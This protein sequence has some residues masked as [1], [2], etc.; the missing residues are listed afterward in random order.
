[1]APEVAMLATRSV[2]SSMATLG[3]SPAASSARSF[4]SLTFSTRIQ[5]TVGW[6][7]LYIFS[8]GGTPSAWVPVHAMAM[9]SC[10]G[11]AAVPVL[12]DW[13]LEQPESAPATSA[14]QAKAPSPARANQARRRAIRV[15]CTLVL[16][17][18]LPTLVSADARE[19]RIRV[20]KEEVP[21]RYRRAV[22]G[23]AAE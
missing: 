3:A 22:R 20:E 21:G 15:K 1:M 6:S 10:S 19:G 5:G 16:R 17:S 4:C 9:V 13:L 2:V 14:P 23:T 18:G 12:L 11:L 8:S 7:W